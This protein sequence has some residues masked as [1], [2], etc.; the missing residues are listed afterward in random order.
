MTGARLQQSWATGMIT[1][2]E[3]GGRERRDMRERRKRTR[4]EGRE[5]GE[6][7]KRGRMVRERE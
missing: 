5:G 4:R 6:R 7:E 3:E 2:R 1:F